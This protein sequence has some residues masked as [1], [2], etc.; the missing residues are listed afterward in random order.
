MLW[1][2]D[3]IGLVERR[4]RRVH[5]VL[6][7]KTKSIDDHHLDLLWSIIVTE[8][9]LQQ[10][11]GKRFFVDMFERISEFLGSH[12]VSPRSPLNDLFTLNAAS[13]ARPATAARTAARGPII[14]PVRGGDIC[15]GTMSA[16]IRKSRQWNQSIPQERRHQ[17]FLDEGA[18][19]LWR[20]IAAHKV[21]TRSRIE[22]Q[23]SHVIRRESALCDEL[24]HQGLENENVDFAV[25][26][27]ELF[28]RSL[29][30][31]GSFGPVF[32]GRIEALAGN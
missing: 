27:A 20:Q 29:W 25:C 9:K 19:R 10:Q 22:Q 17:I 26:K 2:P 11:G 3:L 18:G 5:P 12:H 8:L 4:S 32:E 28:F 13:P 16:A 1:R 23:G 7:R 14:D 21:Q 31:P 30:S 6:V 15:M 24:A